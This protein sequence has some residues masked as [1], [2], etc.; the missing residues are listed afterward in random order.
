LH[1]GEG[2]KNQGAV[3]KSFIQVMRFSMIPKIE[4]ENIKAPLEEKTRSGE[5]ISRIGAT[6]PAMN[7]GDQAAAV[8]LRLPCVI[9]KEANA[10]AAVK[11]DRR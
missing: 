8:T 4:P 6:L 5:D 9:T 11:D 10:I 7:K 2:F 1:G 3:E